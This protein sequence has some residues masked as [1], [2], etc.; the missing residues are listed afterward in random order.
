M[1]RRQIVGQLNPV[2]DYLFVS[3]ADCMHRNNNDF[4]YSDCGTNY[5]HPFQPLHFYTLNWFSLDSTRQCLDTRLNLYL[6]SL[7]KVLNLKS[8]V[9]AI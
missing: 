5:E 4:S 3:V 2:R 8:Y 9:V 6:L 7:V 1:L